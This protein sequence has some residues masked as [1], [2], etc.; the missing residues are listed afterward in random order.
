MVF[1]KQLI[2]LNLSRYILSRY[3][4]S[5]YII[6]HIYKIGTFLLFS[7][8]RTTLSKIQKSKV[9]LF[10]PSN[11]LL[12]SEQRI[13]YNQFYLSL[14]PQGFYTESICNNSYLLLG[15]NHQSG[16]IPNF[17]KSSVSLRVSIGILRMRKPRLKEVVICPAHRVAKQQH[18]DSNPGVSHK[19]PYQR[20]CQ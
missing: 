13:N 7:F 12:I 11:S 19:N 4:I 20:S 2:T 6:S 5:R 17:F 18:Q 15:T 14:Q 16:T 10:K 9:N 8:T 3:T 1:G